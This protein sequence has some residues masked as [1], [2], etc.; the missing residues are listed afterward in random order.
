M[1]ETAVTMKMSSIATCVG[2]V[3]LIPYICSSLLLFPGNFSL[4]SL[5]MVLNWL[6]K[7]KTNFT[8]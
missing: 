6:K 1:K 2:M 5:K 7:V 8:M 3:L 4:N